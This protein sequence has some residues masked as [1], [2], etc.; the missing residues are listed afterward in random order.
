MS[1]LKSILLSTAAGLIAV[2]GTQAADIPQKANVKVCNLYGDGFSY[3]PNTD[4]CL[5]LGGYVREEFYY[6]YG[7]NVTATPFFGPNINN[8]RGPAGGFNLN[9]VG[10][11]SPTSPCARAR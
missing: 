5:K 8:D 1:I 9:G 11:G 7:Q 4:I 2:A 3:I 6:N 10:S